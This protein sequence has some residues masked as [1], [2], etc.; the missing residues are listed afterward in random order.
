MGSP[1]APSAHERDAVGGARRVGPRES[2]APFRFDDKT[3]LMISPQPWDH[4]AVSKHHYAAELGRRG[5][6]VYFLDP[7]CHGLR[8]AVEIRPAGDAA[9][10]TIVRYRPSFPFAIRFH[11]RPIFDALMRLQIGRIRRAIGRPIDVVWCFD[12]NL[13]SNLRAFGA[14]VAV[15]H[16]VDPI[17]EPHQVRPARTADIVLGVSED[18]L[19]PFRALDVPV[20]CLGHG[21]AR[22]FVAA[23]ENR[24]GD[25]PTIDARGGPQIGY[26]GNLLRLPLNRPL[27]RELV[28]A[29]PD[30]TFHFWGPY[31]PSDGAPWPSTEASAFIEFLQRAPNVRLHGALATSALARAI[32]TID[33]FVISYALHPTESDRSN[34]HK[35]LEYLSTGKVVVASRFSAYENF[36]DLLQMPADGDDRQLPAI[37]ARVL[38]DLPRY[39]APER[40]AQRRAFA[41]QHTYEAH[42]ARVERAIQSAFL[43]PG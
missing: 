1:V 33:V 21:L 37:L 6:R 18:I 14:P 31:Q 5:N 40:Q 36:P 15:Y 17:Q 29:H 10:V 42:V 4:I 28:G 7:P 39:N 8:D 32:Q 27:W 2:G 26:F 12:F 23:Y 11:A 22:D 13:F 9:N 3:I 24:P 34:S 43:A 19:R 30:A 16:P 38:A 25:A 41:L 20:V 35:L